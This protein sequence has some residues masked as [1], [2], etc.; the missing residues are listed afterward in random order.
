M[1]DTKKVISTE[2]YYRFSF[3]AMEFCD[4]NLSQIYHQYSAF[5][6]SMDEQNAFSFRQ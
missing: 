5:S 4:L 6:P 3:I 1:E 2:K